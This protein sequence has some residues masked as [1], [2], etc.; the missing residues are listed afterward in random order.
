MGF[1]GWWHDLGGAQIRE[2]GILGQKIPGE[3]HPGHDDL[4]CCGSQAVAKWWLDTDIGKPEGIFYRGVVG[5][6]T[7]ELGFW[8]VGLNQSYLSAA[9]LGQLLT[10]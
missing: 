8:R 7:S 5:P 6:D 9:R 1:D 2:G 4:L 10:G 3:G